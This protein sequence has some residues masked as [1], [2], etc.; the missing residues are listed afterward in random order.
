MKPLELRL[1]GMYSYQEEVHIDFER[2]IEGRLFGIFGPVGSGKSTLLEAITYAL[3]GRSERLDR[4]GQNYNMMN[5]RSNELFID[6][7]FAL[8]G[9]RYRF[10]VKGKRNRKK[11]QDVRSFARIAYVEKGEVW[12]PL[13]SND[14]AEVLGLS[15]ENFTK[16]IIIPQGKFQE[17][18]HLTAGARTEMLKEL[19][20]LGRFDLFKPANQLLSG[21]KEAIVEL[22]GRL[23]ELPEVDTATLQQQKDE[24]EAR[25]RELEA[26]A[27]RLAEQRK[28]EMEFE[29]VRD[30]QGSVVEVLEALGPL[31]KQEADFARR[32]TELERYVATQQA[33]GE[34]LRQQ[35]ANRENR[36]LAE[37][38]L[39][40][41][42]EGEAK[43][44]QEIS[45]AEQA[46]R[47]TSKAFQ[48]REEWRIKEEEMR[49]I[50]GIQSVEKNIA[51]VEARLE[52]GSGVVTEA[53]AQLEALR[54][55]E[56]AAAD[57]VREQK[58]ALPDQI[59]LLEVQNWRKEGDRLAGEAT[60]A[61]AVIE[62][63]REKLAAHEAEGTALLGPTQGRAP[64]EV[65]V[66]R[67]A[68]EVEKRLS[69]ENLR[70]HRRLSDFAE[71][72]VSGQPCPLCGAR[73]HPAP[74]DAGRNQEQLRAEEA[75]LAALGKAIEVLRRAVAEVRAWER[76]RPDLE[77]QLYAAIAGE[78]VLRER[79]AAHRA[80]FVWPEYA[81]KGLAELVGLMDEAKAAARA[82]AEQ[83]Q[84]REQLARE[85]RSWEGKL[86]QYRE[87]IA[88]LEQEKAGET[89]RKAALLEQLQRFD[90]AAYRSK[91][92]EELTA[93]A[94]FFRAEYERI[95]KDYE[96][97]S[98]KLDQLRDQQQKL[99][100]DIK[101]EQGKI[102]RYERDGKGIAE[103]LAV[104]LVEFGF[105]GLEEVGEVLARDWKVA[106]ERARIESYRRDLEQLRAEL[107][108][109]R[110][111]LG[112]RSYDRDAH[113]ALTEE[114]KVAEAQE[115]EL[116]QA[117]GTLREQ[118]ARL[119]EQAK[120]RLALEEEQ[121]RLQDRAEK[122]GTISYMFRGAGF[123]NFVSTMYLQELCLRANA[124]FRKLTRNRLSLEVREDNA[125]VVRDLVNGGQL[126]SVKTLSGGQTFQASLSLALA[127]S[128]NIQQRHQSQYNLFFLDEGFGT[129]DRESL[130][131][132]FDT[133]KELRRE[134]RIVGVISHVEDLQQEIDLFLR[135]SQD[136]ENGS[137]VR[138]RGV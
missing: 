37:R 4:S 137:Q 2:L 113:A 123:V 98:A 58:A 3:Y 65:L 31:E 82:L 75:E 21:A 136:E 135:V 16:T 68:E 90:Y 114:R 8:R 71:A 109:F 19:F 10:T 61:Q 27:Q 48:H 53:Q 92:S 101:V 124:R 67:T 33:F 70:V 32:A 39:G 88:A 118:L 24:L 80:A 62:Q 66:E 22:E 134:N 85:V 133:L 79:V 108:S 116:N 87:A 59:R 119:D 96:A 107:S 30:L 138:L 102:E 56:T 99:Q 60:A 29:A 76:Q 42:R 18:L 105:A 12:E 69:L 7:I 127:L 51:V 26:L 117:I 130:G 50:V 9:T 84:R 126:R 35:K 15:Y 5:L 36:R 89:G 28:Q 20:D 43:L 131:I 6:Y 72:L 106:E 47:G 77:E 57:A 74:Y 63:A 41:Y 46:F 64:A 52:K 128:D 104:R 54:E 23:K 111:Q 1:K 17:F 78:A 44:T 81:E 95:G 25:K 11:F 103:T 97:Q 83:E 112:E 125:F 91:P 73:E 13:E 120:K 132:V 45:T 94:D 100:T 122:L 86:V 40:R 14:G 121:N 38:D 55:R 110:K 115:K 34:L 129:L 93:K 49:R